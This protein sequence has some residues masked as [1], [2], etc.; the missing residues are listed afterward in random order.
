MTKAKGNMYNFVTH[1]HNVIKGKCPHGCT[2]CY[3]NKLYSRKWLEA[4][5]LYLDEKELRKNLGRGNSIFV[6]S[7]CDMWAAAVPDEWII[8]VLRQIQVYADN[9]YFLQTKNPRRFIDFPYEI[10]SRWYLGTTIETN[11]VYPFMGNIPR[12]VDRGGALDVLRD[13]GWGYK[14]FITIEQIIDFDL[15]DF[16]AILKNAHPEFI[17]IGA[18]SGNNHLPEPE[19]E[20]IRALIKRLDG[21]KINIKKNLSRLLPKKE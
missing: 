12:P 1:T 18:D 4:K 11:R 6:G 20:K 2:Y 14:T 5:P 17:N 19:P 3:M 21:Y 8:K 10:I 9:K 16:V 13:G 7:S 15:N